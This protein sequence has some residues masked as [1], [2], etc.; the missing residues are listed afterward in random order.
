MKTELRERTVL[1]IGGTS[2]S[3]WPTN[4]PSAPAH[5]TS[6]LAGQPAGKPGAAVADVTSAVAFA[7]LV[8]VA[9]YS[10]TKAAV[11]SLTISM[12]EQPTAAHGGMRVAEFVAETVAGLEAGAEE[13]LVG[14]SQRL[15]AD[16]EGM[17]DRG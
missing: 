8:T 15:K 12:R 10:A 6:L 3:G 5:R 16:P 4:S 7:P 2:G 11:Q 9:F 17:F 1:I 14:L 13:I